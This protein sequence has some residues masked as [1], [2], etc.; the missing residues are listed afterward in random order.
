VSV[1]SQGD[2][3]ITDPDLPDVEQEEEE[4]E[5]EDAEVDQ[6]RG[7]R[8]LE[9]EQASDARDEEDRGT[10]DRRMGRMLRLGIQDTAALLLTDYRGLNKDKLMGLLT[11]LTTPALAEVEEMEKRSSKPWNDDMLM[12]VFRERLYTITRKVL[13]SGYYDLGDSMLSLKTGVLSGD[14]GVTIERPGPNRTCV[15]LGLQSYS[16]TPWTNSYPNDMTFSLIDTNGIGLIDPITSSVRITL[17]GVNVN[18]APL[19]TERPDG[20]TFYIGIEEVT[21]EYNRQSINNAVKAQYECFAMPNSRR[22][23]VKVKIVNG[24][25]DMPI[26]SDEINRLTVRLYDD[27]KELLTVE[28]DVYGIQSTAWDDTNHAFI[29]TLANHMIRNADRVILRGIACVEDL[30][31]FNDSNLFRAQVLSPTQISIPAWRDV[32]RTLA[33]NGSRVVD[34]NNVI[35]ITIGIESIN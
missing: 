13:I 25:I 16:R 10:R 32:P 17:R 19:F 3:F 5:E 29:I 31:L 8:G 11:N 15:V 26:S 35:K 12:R 22:S 6:E 1:S 9:T 23:G 7:H 2:D 24:T 34:L 4:E 20:S 21:G 14:T 30:N 18:S 27:I 28:Q 33:T